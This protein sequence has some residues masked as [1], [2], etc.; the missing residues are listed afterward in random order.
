[1]PD[2]SLQSRLT[3]KKTE[4]L[5]NIKGVFAAKGFD[6]ASMQDL[7]RAADMSAGNFYRYF[8]SKNAIIEA[9]VESKLAELEASFAEVMRSPN[10]AEAFREGLRQ[11]L[12]SH[13]GE[14]EDA[15]WAEIEA[16]STR[17]PEV[18][19]IA[20]RMQDTVLGYFT[21]AFAYMAGISLE[22][23]ERR[24]AAHASMIILLVK[25]KAATAGASCAIGRVV[26]DRSQFDA[27]VFRVVDLVLSE[28]TEAKASTTADSGVK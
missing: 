7:A 9:I 22:E 26:S 20:I 8:P 6:G 11:R 18:A 19:E 25:V 1:M 3:P 10:P 24:F 27:L 4:I 28:I 14:E 17:R 23:A 15:I 13:H 21:R 16:A 12:Q 2:D 5:E